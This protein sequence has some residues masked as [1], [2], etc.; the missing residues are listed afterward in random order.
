[1]EASRRKR[2]E[3]TREMARGMA[4]MLAKGFK[5]HDVGDHA[6][7]VE[8]FTF[9]DRHQFSELG[10]ENLR[11]AAEAFVD[12]LEAKDDV[13]LRYLRDGTFDQEGLR[14]ADYSEPR[15]HLR[16]RAAIIG[17]EQAYAITK[18]EAWRKHKAGGDYWTPFVRSQVYELRAALDD[19]AY[20]D[21]PRAG[22]SGPGP[23]P[24]RYMLAFE[25]H[26]MKT[27]EHWEQGIEALVP[28]FSL[29]L[30]ATDDDE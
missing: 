4:E 13:E 12:A 7:A 21:K 6:E 10:D 5:A 29:I 23:D 24:M 18:A 28:Y 17:A 19:P 30:E 26:D 11:L 22:K 14:T 20:P 3:E 8:A 1:M 27:E 2:G 15:Q 25:L 16:R 9:V